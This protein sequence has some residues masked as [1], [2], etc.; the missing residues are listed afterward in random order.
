MID[1]INLLSCLHALWVTQIPFRT[2]IVALAASHLAQT[3]QSTLATLRTLG[4]G[5]QLFQ[6]RFSKLEGK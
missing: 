3:F 5:I 1:A 2:A 4:N 6:P